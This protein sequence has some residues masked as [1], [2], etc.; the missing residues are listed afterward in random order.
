MP[1]WTESPQTQQLLAACAAQPPPRRVFVYRFGETEAR[2]AG[3]RVRQLRQIY[4]AAEPAIDTP[5]WRAWLA[6]DV[7]RAIRE[8]VTAAAKVA[9]ACKASA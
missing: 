1:L 6:L 2:Y 5:E 4:R 9:P 7:E 8:A 3:T